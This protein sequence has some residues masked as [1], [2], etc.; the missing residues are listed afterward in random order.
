MAMALP[1]SLFSFAARVIG[2]RQTNGTRWLH[3]AK[4]TLFSVRGAG[5]TAL[6]SDQQLSNFEDE[7]LS[8]PDIE[9]DDTLEHKDFFGVR[10]LCTP[11]LL[12][13]HKVHFGHKATSLDPRMRQF[14]YGI[15]S[16]H[17]IFDLDISNFHLQEALNIAAHVA[18]RD[19][20]I[21]FVARLPHCANLIEQT[22]KDCGEYA[23]VRQWKM[24]CLT[25]ISKYQKMECRLP[26]LVILPSTVSEFGSEH[27]VVAE[28]AK[29]NIPTIGIV[30]SNCN[31]NMIT[32][33][34]PGN[35][36]TLTTIQLYCSLF[37]EAIL[38]GK[39]E[40]A[41]RLKLLEE[42]LSKDQETRL[43]KLKSMSLKL[44]K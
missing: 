18:L 32:Y 26:D 17:V 30:D 41:N 19:G 21:L 29:L 36:D 24:G 4:G 6:Q 42:E 20:I 9:V 33:P 14:V 8:T 25:D 35:D 12:F 7:D 37:K 13:Q 10:K 39:A 22:A 23:H 44:N 11:S 27:P 28:A 38:R 31:P 15:R 3:G 5:E 16:N 43:S 1:S 34:V 40:R 2:L